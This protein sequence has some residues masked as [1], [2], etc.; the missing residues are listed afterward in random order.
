MEAEI[1]PVAGLRKPDESY[2]RK[3]EMPEN[4]H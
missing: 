3:P 1:W 2:D 4:V